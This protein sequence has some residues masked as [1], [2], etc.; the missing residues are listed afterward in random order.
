MVRPGQHRRGPRPPAATSY[1]LQDES[2]TA[3]LSQYASLYATSAS[4]ARA[5]NSAVK[6]YSE[7]STANGTPDQMTAAAESISPDGFYVA[8]PGAIPQ[9]DQFFQNLKAA[10]ATKAA[11]PSAGPATP[12]PRWSARHPPW[13]TPLSAADLTPARKAAT[14]GL[15][16]PPVLVVQ[17]L[18]LGHVEPDQA[19]Q[20]VP[21]DAGEQAGNLRG[22]PGARPDADLGERGSACG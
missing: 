11:R 14:A 22:L 17:A 18:M 4:Q 9:V 20:A 6:V 15:A 16:E 1:I 8:A 3:N 7:V 5:A 19:E 10:L 2:N 12:G 13:P 21:A